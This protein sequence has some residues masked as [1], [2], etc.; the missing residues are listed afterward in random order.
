MILNPEQRARDVVVVAASSGGFQ[1]IRAIA[2]AMPAD[3]PAGIAIVLH[4]GSGDIAGML[5]A[6]LQ[7]D[8]RL[9]VVEPQDG[10]PFAHGMLYLAPAG[11]HLVLREGRFYRDSGPRENFA[12][13]A[14]NPLFRSAAAELGPR[15]LG[16]VLSGGDSDGALG[17]RA[18]TAG[19]GITLAQDP[20]E[21]GDPSMPRSVIALDDVSAVLPLE[22]L[23]PAIVA[24]AR[25][26]ALSV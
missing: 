25:G 6:I 4:R 21:A 11:Q 16:V 20:H 19:G 18:I 10:D 12:R 13:P 1:P 24:L 5:P 9:R 7:R 15:V 17:A 22:R 2:A 23:I 3:L 14:A 26:E 8:S